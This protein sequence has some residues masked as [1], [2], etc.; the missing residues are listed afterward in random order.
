[1]CF[2]YLE[3]P[4][5]EKPPVVHHDR[6]GGGGGGGAGAGGSG[7]I[8][9]GD[10][11]ERDVTEDESSLYYIIRN[12]KSAI[13]VRFIFFFFKNVVCLLQLISLISFYSL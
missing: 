13:A 8:G 12:S 3:K 10:R 11:G 5:V 6:A 7:G 1:M 4:F 2:V 9:S